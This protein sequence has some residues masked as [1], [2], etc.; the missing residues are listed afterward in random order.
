MS[1]R[2]L[3]DIIG[4]WW[5]SQRTEPLESAYKPCHGLT[6]VL[7]LNKQDCSEVVDSYARKK[8][9]VIT[10]ER[11]DRGQIVYQA[12]LCSLPESVT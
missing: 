9:Q 2:L 1:G 4:V 10:T 6:Q 7:W 8:S 12:R 11:T 3:L 5:R